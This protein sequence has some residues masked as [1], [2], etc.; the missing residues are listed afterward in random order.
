MDVANLM[1]K[2]LQFNLWSMRNVGQRAKENPPEFYETSGTKLRINFHRGQRA[3]M[4][5]K[6]R[7]T[8]IIAGTQSGKTLTG[9]EWLRREITLRGPGDYFV[10]GPHFTLLE[11]KCIPAFRQLFEDILALGSY[12]ASPVRHFRVSHNGTRR[13]FGDWTSA[14]TTVYFGYAANS[15]SLESATGKGFWL[16]E[17]GQKKFRLAS[18]R[19]LQRRAAVHQARFLLTSTPYDLGWLKTEIYDKR[20]RDIQVINFRSIENPVFPPEEYMRARRDLPVWMFRMFYMGLFERPVGLVYDVFDAVRHKIPR[21]P[22]GTA[23]RAWGVDFGGV[24]T[25]VLKYFW[26]LELGAWVLYETYKPGVTRTAVEHVAALLEGDRLPEYCYGGSRS[27]AQWRMEFRAAGL[28][29]KEPPV[30]DVELGILRVYGAHKR[31]GIYVFDD[32][33]EYLDEKASYSREVDEAGVVQQG[34]RDKSA[35]HC[36][37]A[38]RYIFSAVEAGLSVGAASRTLRPKDPLAELSYGGDW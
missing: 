31:N 30:S 34:L 15:E 7:I 6:A 5:S 17:P 38:E 24:N 12:K 27:E 37:D 18:W 29:I 16:D 23:E 33:V 1:V 13:L 4:D 20:G 25:C 3:A 36:M 28:E 26:D 32:Q 8:A 14:P 10:V 2:R 19:A 35:F 21:R 11:L 22:V 9:P